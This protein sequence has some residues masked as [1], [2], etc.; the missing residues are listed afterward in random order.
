MEKVEEKSEGS[1]RENEGVE[2]K[3]GPKQTIYGVWGVNVVLVF[4][5]FFHSIEK[6]CAKSFLF[7]PNENNWEETGRCKAF[8][9]RTQYTV[10]SSKKIPFNTGHY[11]CLGQGH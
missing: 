11:W 4:F 2:E 1:K 10:T 9:L 6:V 8:L 7:K 3:Y 5:F